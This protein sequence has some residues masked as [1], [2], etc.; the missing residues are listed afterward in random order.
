MKDIRVVLADD[1]AMVR[2]SIRHLLSKAPGIQVVG[3]AS[4]GE[5]AIRTVNCL[6][7]DVLLLDMEMPVLS[8]VQVAR[9]LQATHSP[10]RILVLSAYDDKQYIREVL[11][12]GAAGYLTK[13]EAAE[14]VVEAIRSI[15]N[16]GAG[17]FSKRVAKKV[18]RHG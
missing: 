14:T 5:E 7:P 9:R 12:N 11:N 16:G 15:A 17:W 1:H 18:P 8:G 2:T 10:V 13:D 6:E 4:N 3:E